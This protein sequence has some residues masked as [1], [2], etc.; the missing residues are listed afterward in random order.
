MSSI[1]I[2][3]TAR[4][5]KRPSTAERKK[6]ARIVAKYAVEDQIDEY[7]RTGEGYNWESFFIYDPNDP[8]EPDV[9]FEGATGL[10]NNS[11]DAVWEGLQHW[12]AAL[13]EIRRVLSD[14]DWDVHVNDHEIVWVEESGYDP[15]Q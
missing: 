6:V 11:E 2:Y 12:C 10:P 14:A 9:I 7:N 5:A 3:F 15:S 4:R 1:S 13:T 8:S